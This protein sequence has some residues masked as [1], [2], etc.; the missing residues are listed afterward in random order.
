MVGS[1]VTPEERNR[2]A[3]LFKI[4][5]TLLVGLSAGLV[6]LHVDA[7]LEFTLAAMLV[8]T[9]IGALMTWLLVRNLRQVQPDGLKE[10]RRRDR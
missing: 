8:G 3:W 1:S 2:A 4:G 7:G 5:F 9:V 10:R 6:S